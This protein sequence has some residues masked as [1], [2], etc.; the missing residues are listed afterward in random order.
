MLFYERKGTV[1]RPKSIYMG[2]Y[3]ITRTHVRLF[4]MTLVI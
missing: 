3:L 2:T 4:V 1:K